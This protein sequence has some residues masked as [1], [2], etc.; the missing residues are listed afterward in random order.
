MP[1]GHRFHY[2]LSINHYAFLINLFPLPL[3]SRE[4][5]VY[6]YI[7][8]YNVEKI[9]HALLTHFGD[10]SSLSPFPSRWPRR[11]KW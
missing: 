5:L 4:Q 9:A 11:G 2:S 3:A 7:L 6:N 10:D 8:G 1:E